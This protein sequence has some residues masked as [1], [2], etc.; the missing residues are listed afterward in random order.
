LLIC[1]IV[2]VH[3]TIIKPLQRRLT[4]AI[5]S[6]HPLSLCSC[7]YEYVCNVILA[8]TFKPAAI[9][10]VARLVIQP[11]KLEQKLSRWLWKWRFKG[12]DSLQN[13]RAAACVVRFNRLIDYT[14]LF[15]A[16]ATRNTGSISTR[17]TRIFYDQ[18][19]IKVFVKELLVKHFCTGPYS[20][21]I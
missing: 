1:N 6:H 4:I 12:G 20:T 17:I 3:N 9:A 19:G 14:R 7:A 11:N 5:A 16:R 18:G 2:V 8:S 13:K 10:F 21:C 15:D